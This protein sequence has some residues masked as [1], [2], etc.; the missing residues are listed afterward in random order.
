MKQDKVSF[1][2]PSYNQAAWLPHAVKSCQEQTYKN[3][4]IVIIDDC[5]TDTTDQYINWLLKQGD[6][7]VRYFRNG[8]NLGRSESRNIGN[9]EASGDIICV[10]DSDD[11]A[12]NKRAELTVK[13]LKGCQVCHGSAIIMNAIGISMG[14]AT[15]KPVTLQECIDRKMNGIIHSSM[16]YTKY[17]AMKFPYKSGEISDLGIDDW[18]QQIR[19]MAAGIKFDFI[20]EVICAYRVN[21]SGIS[22]NRDEKRVSEVKADILGGL[23]CGI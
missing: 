18:D 13:K 20:P 19:M 10:L 14:E 17:L 3:I 21:G 1:V 5:S 22:Q 6:N 12:I 16:A 8:K 4:E 9:K 23:K 11:L 7:R 2:I 15:A